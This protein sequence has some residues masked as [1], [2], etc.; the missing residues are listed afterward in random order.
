MEK[1]FKYPRT[2]HVGFSPGKG[3]TDKVLE[4]LSCFRFKK[5]IVT[6]KMDGENFSLYSDGL[7]ARSLDSKHQPW[8]DWIKAKQAELAG[9]IPSGYRICGEYMYARHNIPYDDLQGYFYVFSIWNGTLCMDWEYTKTWAD[10]YKL[11]TPKILYVGFF[12]EEKL[13][14]IAAKVDADEKCEGFIVRNAACFEL[15]DFNK[16]VVKYVKENY[17]Q[18]NDEHWTKNWIKNHLRK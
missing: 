15:E 1:R 2:W 16:N 12:N 13:H 3:G 14:S 17:V 7:H 5:I 18:T 8:R 6:S 11:P 10:F 4:D 9:A